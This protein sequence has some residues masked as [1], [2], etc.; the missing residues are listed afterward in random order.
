MSA[1]RPQTL[2][3]THRLERGIARCNAAAFRADASPDSRPSRAG[4]RHIVKGI[5]HEGVDLLQP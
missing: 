1:I 5:F 2:R 4:V 3:N